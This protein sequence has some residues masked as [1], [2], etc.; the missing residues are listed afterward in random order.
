MAEC[1]VEIL[2]TKT[3]ENFH[4][5]FFSLSTQMC[6]FDRGKKPDTS[7][8][9]VRMICTKPREDAFKEY[10]ELR[11]ISENLEREDILRRKNSHTDR[12]RR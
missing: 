11:K 5:T 2:S 6:C 8:K 3:D 12:I 10:F 4:L 7:R 9:T 1:D